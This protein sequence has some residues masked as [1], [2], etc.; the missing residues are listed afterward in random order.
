MATYLENISVQ[1]V[2]DITGLS[3]S[4]ITDVQVTAVMSGVVAQV[5]SD[6]QITYNDWRVV[7]I[8]NWR[9]N[10][11][12]GSNTVFYVP[13]DKRP[14]GD[15]NSDG[16]I[17]TSDVKA[18]SISSN[19]TGAVRTELTVSSVSDDELGQIT[20]S[21]APSNCVLYF[22]WVS[23][24]VE[25]ETPHPMIKRAIAQLTASMA[26]SRIDVGKISKF[27]I[28]KVSVMQQSEGFKKYMADYK[29]TIFQIKSKAVKRK[30]F[31]SYFAKGDFYTNDVTIG[32]WR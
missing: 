4:D 22:S 9:E 28:G 2:R 12:D 19:S 8:D 21:S 23:S 3:T 20:L 29:Q 15:Y 32:T 24:P 30:D 14:I 11:I 27:K 10:K 16:V 1:D 13:D 7:P 25:L 6:I 17:N 26:Y 18:Y 5:N 31:H